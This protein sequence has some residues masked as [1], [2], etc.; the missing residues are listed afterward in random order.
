MTLS[1]RRCRESIA[2]RRRG[3]RE[4]ENERMGR[5]VAGRHLLELR[6]V[7]LLEATDLVHVDRVELALGLLLVSGQ[8]LVVH[9]LQADCRVI[10]DANDKDSATLRAPL[11]VLL[12][13]EGDV[14][15][16]NVVGRVRRRVGVG[17]HG[18]I[19]TVDYKDAGATVVLGLNSE[20]TVVVAEV[21]GV[22][23]R[24]K[25]FVFVV[26]SL[27]SHHLQAT[28]ATEEEEDGNEDE[29]EKDNTEDDKHEVNHVVGAIVGGLVGIPDHQ[30]LNRRHGGFEGGFREKG[31]CRYVS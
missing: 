29:G 18:V 27:G 30:T 19:V 20:T 1:S 26:Q 7:L 17:Q 6:A 14:N 11:V 24:R 3:E 23:I 16:R 31:R 15:L 2:L 12:I 25:T 5:G 10:A 13:G 8:L 4:C 22:V 9:G 21:L 28:S